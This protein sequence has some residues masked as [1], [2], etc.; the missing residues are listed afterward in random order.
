MLLF[1]NMKEGL[2][3][4]IIRISEEKKVYG[5]FLASLLALPNT[6]DE[7]R[8]IMDEKE[9]ITEEAT[10]CPHCR[11]SQCALHCAIWW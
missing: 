1:L 6:Q 10:S 7:K 9:W 5:F 8:G 2:V 4:P 3:T 11:C